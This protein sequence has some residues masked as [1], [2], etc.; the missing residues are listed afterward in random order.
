MNQ[1]LQKAF[2]EFKK[3]E[4]VSITE[5]QQVSGGTCIFYSSNSFGDCDRDDTLTYTGVQVTGDKD[6]D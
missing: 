2:D 5:M 1:K 4:T 6:R 3:F